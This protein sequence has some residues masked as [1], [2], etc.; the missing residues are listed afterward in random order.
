[1]NECDGRVRKTDFILKVALL[2]LSSL[3]SSGLQ[4]QIRK[5]L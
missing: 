2:P 5:S 4:S 3:L 1:M